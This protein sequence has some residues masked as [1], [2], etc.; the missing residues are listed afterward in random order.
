FARRVLPLT[1]LQERRRTPVVTL[2][3]LASYLAV[4]LYE[5]ALGLQSPTALHRLVAEHAVVPA[6]FVAGWREGEAWLPL[7]TAMFL[8]GGLAHVA[9]NAWFLWVFGRSVENRVGSSS[10]GFFYLFAGAA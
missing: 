2:G 8:H 6:R 1:D 5:V 9:G 3:L 10:Y 4:F 7:L